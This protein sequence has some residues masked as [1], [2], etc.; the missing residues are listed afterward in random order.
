MKDYQLVGGQPVRISPLT[1]TE[2]G[3]IYAPEGC[4]FNPV[5]TGVAPAAEELET[6]YPVNDGHYFFAATDEE[7]T[8]EAAICIIE[9]GAISESYGTG[10]VAI[11]DSGDTPVLTW[12]PVMEEPT[13]TCWYGV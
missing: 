13:I 11:D 5:T 9:D 4:A 1:V 7:N 6:P 3:T 12:T 2:N 8:T 10:S